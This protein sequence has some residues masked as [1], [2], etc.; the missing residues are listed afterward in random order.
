MNFERITIDPKVCHGKACIRGT[1]I[2]VHIILDMIAAGET[3]DNI[4]AAYPHIS[5]EDIQECAKYGA[6]L[7]EEETVPI[8]VKTR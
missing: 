3:F 1:R 5:R 8:E 2:P 7:A 4:L 6:A